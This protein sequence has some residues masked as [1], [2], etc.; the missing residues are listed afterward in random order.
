MK[1]ILLYISLLISVFS[2]A[3]NWCPPGAQWSYRMQCP[4][5]NGYANLW[6]DKDTI[7]DLQP[8]KKI[9][10]YETYSSSVHGIV[11]YTFER[12]DTVFFYDNGSFWPTYFFNVALG[13]TLSFENQMDRVCDTVLYMLVDSVATLS[14]NGETLRY[15]QAHYIG[16]NPPNPSTF[17]MKVM[18]KYGALD[19]Y[20]LPFTICNG[21]ADPCYY[22]L[23]CYAD[24]IHQSN[25]DEPCVT[26]DTTSVKEVLALAS[27]TVYPN[28]AT[29]QLNIS[30]EGHT[31][32]QYQVLDYTSKVIINNQ[33]NDSDLSI[34]VSSLVQGVYLIKLDL[35]NGQFAVRRFI[36]D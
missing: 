9:V 6:Y 28:P 11:M 14:V 36:R 13:D 2:Q 3:Q 29:N 34:N 18:E 7:I 24:S 31:I 35:D 1:T 33:T 17:S 27:L 23:R 5:Q 26:S 20:L 19:N 30:I 10:G 15:Y 4:E 25:P 16:S 32:T 8:C 21:A 12:N 22:N